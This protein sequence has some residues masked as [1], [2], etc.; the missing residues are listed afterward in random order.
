MHWGTL[1]RDKK[2]IVLVFYG[3]LGVRDSEGV[4][5][6]DEAWAIGEVLHYACV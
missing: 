6:S 3:L 1:F 5:D 2:E 4:R